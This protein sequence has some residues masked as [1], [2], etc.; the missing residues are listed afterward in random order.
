[1]DQEIAEI[2]AR[3]HEIGGIECKGPGPASD[4]HLFAKVARAALGMV[5]R[6]DGG[7]IVSG[8]ADSSGVL[9]PKGLNT[10]QI[11]TWRYDDVASKLAEYADPSIVFELEC[12]RHDEKNYVM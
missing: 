7:R 11:D 3:G 2:L 9:E 6:R 1:M 4:S 8:V 12:K 5:N 10:C